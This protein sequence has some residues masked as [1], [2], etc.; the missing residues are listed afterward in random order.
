MEQKI[1]DVV[2]AADFEIIG[3]KPKQNVKGQSPKQRVLQHAVLEDLFPD[4][5]THNKVYLLSRNKTIGSI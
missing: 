3:E 5:L 2:D 1:I 4:E